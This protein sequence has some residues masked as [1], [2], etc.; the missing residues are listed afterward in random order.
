MGVKLRILIPVLSLLFVTAC[1]ATTPIAYDYSQYREEAPRSVLVLPALN[2]SLNVNAPDYFLSTLSAPV[3]ER[4]YYVFPAFMVSRVLEENGLSDAGLVHSADATRLGELFNCD[5]AMY[6]VIERWDSQYV[7]LA[8]QTTVQLGYQLRSCHTGESLWATSEIMTYSPQASNSGNPLADL[9]AQA[10]VAA[11]EKADPNYMPLA[12]QANLLAT[13]RGGRGLPAGPYR[14]EMYG[15][16]LEMFPVGGGGKPAGQVESFDELEETE[17]D[18]SDSDDAVE[19]ADGGQ[20]G[21]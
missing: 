17:N 13:A 11:I 4:G 2:N 5:A 8:T 16:D 15:T 14:P 10:V 3:G 6:V 1:A 18:D 20:S 9:V 19:T 21:S 12:R 7:F